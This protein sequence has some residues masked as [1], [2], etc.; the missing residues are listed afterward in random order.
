MNPVEKQSYWSERYL[1]NQV[2][3]DCGAITPPIKDYIDQLTNKSISILIPGCGSAHEAEYLWMLGFTNV[4]LLDFAPEALALFSERVRDF[5]KEQL[6]C[7]DFFAHAGKYDLIV[8]QTL[9]CAINPNQ[10]KEY[11]DKIVKLLNPTGKLIGV[12]F[13]REFEGGPPFGG[14]IAEY[15]CIFQAEFSS[16]FIEPCYNSIKPREGSEVFIKMGDPT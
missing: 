7:G 11:V 6:H 16:V 9:F 8:E 3:W 2:G 12:L 4:H 1:K 10:R 14:S 13:N 5:P 15:Q